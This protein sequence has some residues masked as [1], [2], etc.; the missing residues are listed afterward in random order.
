[1]YVLN[2]TGSLAF[3]DYNQSHVTKNTIVPE[4]D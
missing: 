4:F 2:T 3:T 1:M